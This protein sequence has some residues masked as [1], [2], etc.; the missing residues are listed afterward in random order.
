LALKT[1]FELG[2]VAK[3]D[4]L[5]NRV[6]AELA[7]VE[8]ADSMTAN[9]LFNQFLAV[10]GKPDLKATGRIRELAGK[11]V[12]GR[13]LALK[14]PENDGVAEVYRFQPPARHSNSWRTFGQRKVGISHAADI[15]CIHVLFLLGICQSR[16][17]PC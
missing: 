15:H 17:G 14:N 8:K 11:F 16:C 13:T 2:L 9:E 5:R 10:Q 1:L 4:T 6:V 12:F 7:A 3:P